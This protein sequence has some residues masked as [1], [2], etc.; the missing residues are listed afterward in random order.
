[1]LSLI[2]VLVMEIPSSSRTYTQY[3]GE[4]GLN[5]ALNTEQGGAEY[6]QKWEIEYCY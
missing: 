2:S 4:E 5:P 1:M 6:F 3:T